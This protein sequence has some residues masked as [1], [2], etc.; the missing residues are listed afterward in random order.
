MKTILSVLVIAAS[1]FLG[2]SSVGADSGNPRPVLTPGSDA[3]FDKR[4]PP[5]LPG[6]EVS[7]GKETMK[8]WSSSGPVPVGEAPELASGNAGSLYRGDQHLDVIVDRRG[9]RKR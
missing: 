6:E 5:V 1:A 4:L 8:V 9:E 2:I 3:S 7:D